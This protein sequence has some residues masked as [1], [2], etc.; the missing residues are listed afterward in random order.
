MLLRHHVNVKGTLMRRYRQILGFFIAVV[1][2][3]G[4]QGFGQQAPTTRA[5][6]HLLWKTDLRQFGYQQ[7]HH[8][9]VRW[10]RLIVDF[11]DNNH[12]VIGWIS[13]DTSTLS[14]TKGSAVS[15]LA[16]FH[17]VLLDA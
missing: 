14:E 12:I 15:G 1:V 17:V 9:S 4:G 2:L 3:Y 13:P 8:S 5:E 16:H 7:F 6:S 11:T 10:M